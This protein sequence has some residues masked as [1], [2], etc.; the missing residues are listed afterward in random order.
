V[1]QWHP[2]YV[3][4]LGVQAYRTAFGRS[5][6]TIGCQPETV[7]GA[8]LWVLPNPS[9][10]QAAYQLPEMIALYGELR[11]AAYGP[12]LDPEHRI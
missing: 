8:G 4:I 2:A 3:A 10:L 11:T 12:A 7:A 5:K 6:A 1:E 9:G